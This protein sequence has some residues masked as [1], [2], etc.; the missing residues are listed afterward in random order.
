MAIDPS[1]IDRSQWQHVLAP[2]IDHL[3]HS[4]LDIVTDD[5]EIES[6]GTSFGLGL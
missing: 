2:L 5:L 6:R 1:T 3:R 4:G